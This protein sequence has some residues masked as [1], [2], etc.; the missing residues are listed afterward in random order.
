LL[1]LALSLWWAFIQDPVQTEITPSRFLLT[2][3][4]SLDSE[5]SMLLGDNIV[6]VIRI[7]WLMLRWHVNFFVRQMGAI[8]VF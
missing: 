8:E 2:L 7:Q 6:F 1:V 4:S 5:S 3:G